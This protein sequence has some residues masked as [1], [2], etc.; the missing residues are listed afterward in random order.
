MKIEQT[1]WN[2][3]YRPKKIE[4]VVLS[5]QYATELRSFIKN[6]DIPNLLF[7]GPAGGGKTTLARII[8]SKNGILQIPNS[9]LLEINGSAK[10]TRGIN[11]VSTVI[12]PF[13]RVPPAGQDKYKIVFIDE[14]DN[15]TQDSIL[16]LRG[17]IE[18]Y[19]IKYGRFI[20]TC[21][22]I[23]KFPSPFQSRFTIYNFKQIPV[24]FVINYCKTILDS[25][26]IKYDEKDLKFIV[27]NLYP[28]VRKITNTI[29]RLSISGKLLV[30]KDI[31]LSTEKAII[32]SLIEIYGYIKDKKPHKINKTMGTVI[33]LIDNQ[34]LE[35]SHIYTSLFSSNQVPVPAKIV[36]NK[37]ANS[38]QSCLVPFMHF[39]AMVMESM[40]AVNQYYE[41]IGKK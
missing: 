24:E 15:L 9:N 18:K 26:S 4:D 30:N 10:E 23:S 12:E 2:E 28:D 41:S 40:T 36:I 31:A 34:D 8:T 3:K 6:R 33:S 7:S 38:H 25:E 14:G 13:L 21:N 39:S 17:V 19:Q 22:Y 11:F 32:G 29:Q 16:S 27:E 35:F 37:S 20:V 1:L 5:D